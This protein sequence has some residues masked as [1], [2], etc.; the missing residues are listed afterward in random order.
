MKMVYARKREEIFSHH[1]YDLLK[2]KDEEIE[3][4]KKDCEWLLSFYTQVFGSGMTMG[5]FHNKCEDIRKKYGLKE[6]GKV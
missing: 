5:E 4:L 6:M 1:T 2:K 3:N